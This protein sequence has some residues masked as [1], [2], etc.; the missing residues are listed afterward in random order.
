MRPSTTGWMLKYPLLSTTWNLSDA[1]NENNTGGARLPGQHHTTSRG[2]RPLCDALM[3][4]IWA[5]PCKQLVL[6]RLKDHIQP[7]NP[8][9][10]ATLLESP[11]T[12]EEFFTALRVGTRQKHLLWMAFSMS[13]IL[14]IWTLK[15]GPPCGNQSHVHAQHHYPP[16]NTCNL[17]VS[18]SSTEIWHRVFT[19]QYRSWT[20]IT[21]L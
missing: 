4:A 9:V 16:N 14:S 11:I 13:S 1:A 3:A 18:R 8:S 6:R 19:A 10:F 21:Y 5:H 15:N 7:T 12:Y 20:P 2:H 17:H